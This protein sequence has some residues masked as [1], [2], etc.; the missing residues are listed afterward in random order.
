MKALEFPKEIVEGFTPILMKYGLKEPK[1]IHTAMLAVHKVF[2]K[3][4]MNRVA[5][6]KVPMKTWIMRTGTDIAIELDRLGMA[7]QDCANCSQDLLKFVAELIQREA[8]KHG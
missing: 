5:R 7:P 6:G 1:D 2:I 8:K 3:N 4:D